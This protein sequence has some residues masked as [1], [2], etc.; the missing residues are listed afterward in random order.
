M[1]ISTK[2]F[3][4]DIEE[5]DGYDRHNISYS[6]GSSELRVVNKDGTGYGQFVSPSGEVT[7]YEIKK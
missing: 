6:N 7:R 4:D 2:D 1:Q 3:I 5:F